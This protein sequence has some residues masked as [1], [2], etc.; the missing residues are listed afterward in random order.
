MGALPKRRISKQRKNNR[1]AHD[2]L[3]KPAVV[4]CPKCGKPRRPH[5][6][7]KYCGHYGPKPVKKE[8]K[9]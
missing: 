6:E 3:K 7:C 4:K 2:A 8:T 5:F 9:K 1:R